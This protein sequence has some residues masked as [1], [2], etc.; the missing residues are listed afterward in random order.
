MPDAP[1]PFKVPIIIPVVAVL[2]SAALVV[3]PIVYDPKLEYLAVLGFFALGVVI[4]IPFVYYK[5]RLPGMDGFTR[6]VQYLTLAAPSPYKD[7]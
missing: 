7:D 2:I 4:Y 3:L 6:A 5:Y 1:R